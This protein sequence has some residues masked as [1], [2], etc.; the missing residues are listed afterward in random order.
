MLSRLG[1]TYGFGPNVDIGSTGHFVK[2]S[3][4]MEDYSKCSSDKSKSCYSTVENILGEKVL[5]AVR[6]RTPTSAGM[7]GVILDNINNNSSHHKKLDGMANEQGSLWDQLQNSFF[8]SQNDANTT[9]HMFMKNRPA[10]AA[11]N[12][13]G[14]CQS[15]LVSCKKSSKEKLTKLA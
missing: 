13:K 1:L 10:I 9:L 6:A 7:K 12:L 14:Q 11:D 2:H 3:H 15:K 4:V 5:G 8:I